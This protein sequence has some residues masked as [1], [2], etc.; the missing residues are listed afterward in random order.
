MNFV[1]LGNL[2][3]K[4]E[5]LF[6]EKNCPSQIMFSLE[7]LANFSF[8]DNRIRKIGW[9]DELFHQ[10]YVQPL[11]DESLIKPDLD[12]RKQWAVAMLDFYATG[13]TP[14]QLHATEIMKYFFLTWTIDGKTRKKLKICDSEFVFLQEKIL[15]LNLIKYFVVSVAENVWKM[16]EEVCAH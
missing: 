5:H 7:R 16:H 14:N 15:V 2:N 9:S 11:I 1:S 3:N 4:F 12:T 8:P 10:N 6:I 13:K